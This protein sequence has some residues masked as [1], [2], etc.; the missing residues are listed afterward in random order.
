MVI[1]II[2]VYFAVNYGFLVNPQNTSGIW[3]MVSRS[4][5]GQGVRER[6]GLRHNSHTCWAECRRELL[7][8]SLIDL[9]TGFQADPP[10]VT[11][12]LSPWLREPLWVH[13][14]KIA[15]VQCCKFWD[16]G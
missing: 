12:A 6:Q 8:R 13:L 2:N 15:P 1:I 7:R 9:R 4:I 5:H 10:A 3:A 16:E 11:T 14:I